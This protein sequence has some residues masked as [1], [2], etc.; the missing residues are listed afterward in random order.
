MKT[1]MPED[2]DF[3]KLYDKQVKCLRLAGYQR[4]TIEAYTR[5]LRRIGNYFNGRID[6]LTDDQ[7]LD[8]F[9]EVVE[10]YSWSTLKLDIHGLKFFYEHVLQ[11]PWEHVPLVKPPKVSRIPDVLSVEE[12]GRLVAASLVSSY[13]VFFF[14]AYSL[15]LRLSE[16]IALRVGD[17]DATNMRDHIRDSKG[18][19]DRLVPLPQNTLRTLRNFWLLHRHP[20]FIFPSRKYGRK[21][22]HR[23]TIPL[24]RS[25]VQSAMKKIVSQ[26]GIKKK[27]PATPC[28]TVTPHTCWNPGLI[29]L[30]Y[31][32]SWGMSPGFPLHI[33]M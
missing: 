7:L 5:S 9:T 14:T 28:G 19:K 23:A 31:R 1:S 20:D 33:T 26:L 22:A 8:Y 16:G 15:G 2:S 10:H 12:V 17:I 18:N 24:D 29:L 13:K 25:G 4:K 11:R 32:R 6:N 3:I 27:F 21:H 30:S